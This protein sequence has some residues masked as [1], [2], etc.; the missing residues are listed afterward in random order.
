MQKFIYLLLV[1]V[2]PC[3][4]LAATESKPVPPFINPH[5]ADSHYPATHAYADLTPLPGPLARSHRLTGNEVQWK[6]LGPFNTFPQVYSGPYP[7]GKRVIWAGGYDRITKLDAYTLETLTTYAI[8][9]NTFYDEEET[10]RYVAEADKADDNA[11]KNWI[12]FWKDEP[13]RAAIALYKIVTKDNH[14]YVPHWSEGA[15]SLREYAE[16]DPTDPRSKIKLVREWKVPPEVSKSPL[17]GMQMTSD[18]TIVMTTQDGILIAITRDF[19]HYETVKLPMQN[20]P[21]ETRDPLSSFVRNSIST[22]DHGGIYV[23]TRDGLNRVQWTGTKLSLDTADGGWSVPYPNG[24][25]IG[26]GTTP[27]LMGWGTK[28]D[29]LVLIADSNANNELMAF[30]RDEIPVDWKGLPGFDRRVAGIVPINFGIGKVE[31][32]K[33]ENALEVYGYGAFTNPTYP[34]ATEPQSSP[35]MQWLYDSFV[36]HVPGHEPLG[37]AKWEWNPSTRT[38]R[39]VWQTQTNLGTMICMISGADDILYCWGAQNGEW[40]VK[41]LDWNTGK[42]NF[43]YTLGKSQRF[44]PFGGFLIINPDRT[45]DCA[46]AFGPVRIKPK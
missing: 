11:H 38:L 17:F 2:L 8:G 4:L 9:G 40:T 45:I 10:R 7:N 36:T 37:G 15:F 41:G 21:G 32:N 16:V 30:W 13:F 34:L 29:H 28:E 3:T 24:L 6:P 39:T 44:N 35:T 42:I 31:H 18:G 20:G 46:C 5:L 19:S 22:D 25:G 27:A 14:L 43:S 26:S 1:A 12:K 33:L 23:V